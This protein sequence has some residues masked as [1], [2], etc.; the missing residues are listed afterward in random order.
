VGPF[1]C[2]GLGIISKLDERI[3][4]E[5]ILGKKIYILPC[6][7]SYFERKKIYI[8]GSEPA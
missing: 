6:C 3:L 5:E 2:S 4:W 8:Y 7:S 1:W